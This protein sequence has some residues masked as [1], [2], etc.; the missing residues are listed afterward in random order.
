[1]IPRLLTDISDEEAASVVLIFHLV[2]DLQEHLNWLVLFSK[3]AVVFFL[4]LGCVFSHW[5]IS[6]S[7][8][9]A[10]GYISLRAE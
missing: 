5:F 4:A 7:Y 8:R 1:M 9:T 2:N 10:A 6:V 3:W